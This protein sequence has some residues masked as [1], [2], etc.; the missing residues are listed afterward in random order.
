M[1]TGH[2]V[3]RL[4]FRISITTLG[5]FRK[6]VDSFPANTA[7]VPSIISRV[8]ASASF[9]VNSSLLSYRVVSGTRFSS[10]GN[11]LS[12][13]LCT[14][15]DVFWYFTSCVLAKIINLSKFK[16]KG[17]NRFLQNAGHTHQSI[18]Q[19]TESSSAP[20]SE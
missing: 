6:F 18:S 2:R 11:T 13:H 4:R 12:I 20:L 19:N 7:I 5:I 17:R 9:P 15:V 8:F 1:S 10:C 3:C 14:Y 16:R